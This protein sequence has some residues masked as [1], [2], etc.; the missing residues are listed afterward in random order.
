[1]SGIKRVRRTAVMAALVSVVSSSLKKLTVFSCVRFDL[2]S[3]EGPAM[4]QAF[5]DGMMN[6]ERASKALMNLWPFL[7][8]LMYMPFVGA[9]VEL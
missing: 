1:M 3:R 7:E 4:E 6:L 9:I 8:A 5:F 2:V